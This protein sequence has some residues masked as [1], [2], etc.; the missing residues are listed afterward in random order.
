MFHFLFCNLIFY[1]IVKSWKY[2]LDFKFFE[3][4]TLTEFTIE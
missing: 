2:N 4:G 1:R 3:E